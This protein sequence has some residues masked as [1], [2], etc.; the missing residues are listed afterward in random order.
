MK[1]L[2]EPDFKTCVET[3]F[4]I[5]VSLKKEYESEDYEFHIDVSSSWPIEQA[6]INRPHD[7][8]M[9]EAAMRHVDGIDNRVKRYNRI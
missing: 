8:S 6:I 5:L 1:C 7:V 9:M 4:N 2:E 3:V